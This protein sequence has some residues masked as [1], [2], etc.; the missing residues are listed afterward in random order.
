MAT[1]S[2]SI[3]GTWLRNRSLV[4]GS[5]WKDT[6]GRGSNAR[7]EFSKTAQ[8]KTPREAFWHE[9]GKNPQGKGREQCWLLAGLCPQ[10]LCDT[11]TTP[12]GASL[13]PWGQNCCVKGFCKIG[14]I[15]GAQNEPP[16]G[17]ASLILGLRALPT[18]EPPAPGKAL[19]WDPCC[20]PH[21]LGFGEPPFS[22]LAGKAQLWLPPDQPCPLT[23]AL[24]C[25]DWAAQAEPGWA[26]L[27][28][29]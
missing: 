7:H 15:T 11:A 21:S 27:S 25:Q 20:L 8:Q 9:R 18:S 24:L 6:Q 14:A 17:T 22:F 19:C 5:P 29:L 23:R 3:A 12:C 4:T 2:P 13:C 16:A 10:P 26:G 28:L 1:N